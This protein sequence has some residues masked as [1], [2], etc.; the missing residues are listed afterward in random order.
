MRLLVGLDSIGVVA[1]V[2]GVIVAHS[3]H[4]PRIDVADPVA[5]HLRPPTLQFG[6]GLETMEKKNREE[7]D[8]GSKMTRKSGNEERTTKIW[9]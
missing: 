5:R 2:A 3:K 1:G 4:L 7:E 6:V 9:K 8:I